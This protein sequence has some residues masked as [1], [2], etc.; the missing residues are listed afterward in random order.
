LT[1]LCE[2]YKI[3]LLGEVEKKIVVNEAKYPVEKSKGSNKKYTEL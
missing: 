2:E 3:D 1:Y